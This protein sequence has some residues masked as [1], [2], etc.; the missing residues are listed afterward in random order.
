MRCAMAQAMLRLLATPNTTTVLPSK[1][2]AIC[3]SSS[4]GASEAYRV[5]FRGYQSSGGGVSPQA[6]RSRAWENHSILSLAI[7]PRQRPLG[8]ETRVLGGTCVLRVV[9][10]SRR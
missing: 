9:R 10:H 8:W 7:L 4:S 3:V 1:L 6:S 2:I 5:D